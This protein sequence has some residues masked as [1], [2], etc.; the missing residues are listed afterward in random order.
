MQS[1]LHRNVVYVL[2]YFACSYAFLLAIP[3]PFLILKKFLYTSATHVPSSKHCRLFS[4]HT[5]LC[6]WTCTN[7]HIIL[8]CII[9]HSYHH[10]HHPA[11]MLAMMQQLQEAFTLC[12]TVVTVYSCVGYVHYVHSSVYSCNSWLECEV[13]SLMTALL[14]LLSSRGYMY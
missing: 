8:Y 13:M 6:M 9:T 1:E 10:R 7:L 14:Q 4:L 5:Y 3:N 2:S 11:P 12:F